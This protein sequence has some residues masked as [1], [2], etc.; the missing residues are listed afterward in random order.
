MIQK[1]KNKQVVN[2][3][4]CYKNTKMFYIAVTNS[5]CLLGVQH[6]EKIL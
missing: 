1:H 5:R 4:L 3:P 2:T 6:Q